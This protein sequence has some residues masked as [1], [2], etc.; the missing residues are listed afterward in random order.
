[1][2][3][4]NLEDSGL[5]GKIILK[6]IFQKWDRTRTGLVWLRTEIGGGLL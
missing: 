3:G 1:M 4:G 6:W 5:N 2:E